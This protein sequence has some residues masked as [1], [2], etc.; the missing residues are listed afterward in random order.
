MHGYGEY[1]DINSNILYIG[2]FEN[3]S[4]NGFGILRNFNDDYIYI[5]FWVNNL[6]DGVGKSIKGNNGKFARYLK[7]I[8][9]HQYSS[10]NDLKKFISVNYVHLL[11]FFEFD[12]KDA[13][14]YVS[15][16]RILG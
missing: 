9:T 12:R 16:N 1:H 6:R 10:M 14:K 4:Y 13:A 11:P 8:K 15:L 7:N 5:G 3:N 2:N